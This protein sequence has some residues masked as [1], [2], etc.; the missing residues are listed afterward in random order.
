M[1]D[2]AYIMGFIGGAVGILIGVLVYAEIDK[3]IACPLVSD[4][5]EGNASCLRA[6]SISWTIMVVLPISMFFVLFTVFGGWS[7][8]TI[9]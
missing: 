9:Q 1:L 3:M 4:S 5:P 7:K 2:I 6:K 8:A